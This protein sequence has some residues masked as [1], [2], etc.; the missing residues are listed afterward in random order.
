M[1]GEV[2]RYLGGDSFLDGHLEVGSFYTIESVFE[3]DGNEF[4]T[5]N[6][7]KR[8]SYIHI[9]EANF[10]NISKE[11]DLKLTTLLD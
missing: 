2:H 5:F 8:A 1:I 9:L 4:V 7:T 3:L 11:R 10:K 6:E